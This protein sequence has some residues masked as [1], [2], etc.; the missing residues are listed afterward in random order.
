MAKC[1][2]CVRAWDLQPN[3]A[4][5]FRSA[6]FN[7]QYS[8]VLF[9]SKH[10]R[11]LTTIVCILHYSLIFKKLYYYYWFIA[12]PLDAIRSGRQE[13]VYLDFMS[14]LTPIIMIIA[15]QPETQRWN[16]TQKC[17]SALLTDCEYSSHLRRRN[18][19]CFWILVYLCIFLNL[20]SASIRSEKSLVPKN[21][22]R[23][24][25]IYF[26][27]LAATS[28]RCVCIER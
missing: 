17:S 9:K 27:V 13:P 11:V 7:F 8:D 23:I 14:Q 16:C 21:R 26:F 24:S 19:L 22:K 18:S 20:S 5:P 10:I 4:F 25:L 1:R 28:V 2:A 6:V 12:I 15:H 3:A